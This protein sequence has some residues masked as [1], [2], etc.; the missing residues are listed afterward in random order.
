MAKL[1]MSKSNLLH[2]QPTS[3][4]LPLVVSRRRL[5]QAGLA[6]TATGTFLNSGNL[7]FAADDAVRA[8]QLVAGKDRRQAV[9]PGE[10]GL[11]G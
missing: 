2:S 11:S 9:V 10:A 4:S 6:F 7:A 5:L 1:D 8:D 3:E